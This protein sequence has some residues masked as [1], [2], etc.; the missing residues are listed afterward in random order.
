MASTA[1]ATGTDDVRAVRAFNRFWT[2]QIGL[3]QAGLVDTPWSLTE[4]RVLFELAQQD[5]TDLADLRRALQLD[6]GYLTRIV[7]RLKDAGLVT[8]ERS[9]DDGRR[10]VIRLTKV[11]RAE[12]GTLDGRSSDATAA[13]LDG[14]PAAD[15]RRLVAAMRGIEDT[16]APRSDRPPRA[17]LLREPGPGDLGW[18]VQLN[19]AVYAAEYGWDQSYEALV[20]RIVA[21]FGEH[22]DPARERAWIADLDGEPV[23]CVLCVRRDDETAQLRIL[24]VDPAVRGLGIGARLVEECIRFA[25][26]AGYRSMVLWT[27]DVLVSARRIY[28]AAGF[29]LTDEEPHHSFGHDLVG[30]TWRLDLRP[31][32]AADRATI[33]SPSAA[34]SD[35]AAS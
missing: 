33:G 21:D 5:A 30:Q 34:S 6:A 1:T 16:L 3:L 31:E 4:A 35:R 15:R 12:F 10:Q 23:G 2:Q 17:Y 13:L 18:M 25:R 29:A 22:R 24:L 8:A 11:G 20:A 32:L 7:G 28:E 27:N 14:L 9:A 19:A 26:A